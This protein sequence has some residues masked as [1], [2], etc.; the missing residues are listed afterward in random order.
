MY[1]FAKLGFSSEQASRSPVFRAMLDNEMEE[2]RSG[3]I[4]IYDVPYTSI[5][6]Y[7]TSV[8]NVVANNAVVYTNLL[9]MGSV[10]GASQ[11]CQSLLRELLMA[12]ALAT[13]SQLRQ[14]SLQHSLHL[15]P[16]FS[17]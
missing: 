5:S 16:S 2:S 12:C 7:F 17:E 15:P 1:I 13:T 3:I 4:K 8:Q 10:Q 9:L 14:L 6:L 11:R